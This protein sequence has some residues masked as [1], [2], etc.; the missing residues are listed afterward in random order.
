M[1][2]EP[3]LTVSSGAR[4]DAHVP[5]QKSQ[6]QLS[7]PKEESN[8]SRRTDN[9][10]AEEKTAPHPTV[11]HVQGLS[12]PVVSSASPPE[13]IFHSGTNSSGSLVA[14]STNEKEPQA[15]T[16][17]G[18]A[19]RRTQRAAA[20]LWSM[21]S[22]SQHCEITQDGACVTDGSGD[23]NNNEQCTV[24]AEVAMLVSA[25]AG[26]STESWFDWV[27]LG[28]TQYSGTSGPTGVA[29]NVGE[30][31]HWRS[32]E[33]MFGTGFMI[34]GA[35]AIPPSPPMPQMLPMPPQAPP[36]P[37]MP[38]TPTMPPPTSPPPL[39]P[40]SCYGAGWVS[41]VVAFKLKSLDLNVCTD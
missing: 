38:P 9:T 13:A 8:G 34:C 41:V 19:H 36:M 10:T 23:Y 31:L 30:T 3:A 4:A 21:V 27:T 40:C 24:R 35:Q 18:A 6:A 39:D 32:D 29:M 5:L 25:Q 7:L 12:G 11:Y 1:D 2:V 15:E 26:F 14:T 16:F 22:G 33:T 20:Q 28:G 17:A 37:P